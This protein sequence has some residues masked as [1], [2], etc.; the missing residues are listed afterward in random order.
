MTSE[1]ETSAVDS[2]HSETPRRKARPPFF[3][4]R[5][6]RIV[7]FSSMGIFAVFLLVFGFFYIKYAPTIN[8]RLAAGPF[9]GTVNI[10][11]APRSVAVG[12][13][14]AIDE[15]V[16]RLRRAGY[17]TSRGNTVGWYNVRQHAVEI[18]PGRDSYAGGEPGVLEFSGGKLSRIVS[19]DD[20]T[21]RKVFDLE[22]Q[23]IANLSSQRERRRLVRFSEIPEHLVQAVVSVEDKNFF[24]HAGFDAFRILK[25][26]YVDVKEGRKQQGASTL[27]MQLARGI[28]LDP[29]K[30]WKR[31]L[32]EMAISAHLERKLSKQQI[33]EY[34]A[35]QIYL[36]R[37]GT[38]S[39]HGFG[40]AA[41]VYFSKDLAQVTLPEAALLAGLIQR[42]SYF[43][44]FRH[45]ERAAE[46]RNIVLRLMRENGRLTAEQ[47]EAAAATPV[48]VQA[49][50]EEFTEAQYFVDVMNEEAQAKLAENQEER[51]R[52]IYTTLDPDLQD[53]AQNAVSKGME[54]VDRQLGCGAFKGKGKSRCGDTPPQ[55]ALV[56]IDPRTGEIRALVG[57]RN[58]NASQLNHALA[59][60]QPG[61]VFK[62]FVYA[63]ALE[64]AV[65][66][67][68]SILTPATVMND[69]PTTFY[70]E[71]QVY[72]PGNFHQNYMGPVTIRTA[73]AHS[74]NIATVELAQKVGYDRVVRLARRV[75][76]NEA[77]KPTPAVALGAY[78]TTPLEIAGAYTTFANDGVRVTPTT[79]SLVRGPDGAILYQHQPDRRNTLDP[80]VNYL[81]VSMMQ[82]V[83]RYG[84]GAGVR[85]RGFS[86][87]AAGKTGTSHDGWFAGFTSNLLCVVWV[88]F[89]D[90]RELK[91]EGS[92]SAVPIWAEFMKQATKFPR[93][94]DVRTFRPPSGIVSVEICPE[95]GELAGP[96]CPSDR[97]DMFISG[98]QPA[99]ECRL[100]A[101]SIVNY[102][103]RVVE[104]P[105]P[106]SS[107]TA[108]GQRTAAPSESMQG[109]RK[110]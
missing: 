77:I 82:D 90:N 95:S 18:F 26:A 102:A 43:N 49:E 71:R 85:S 84:T 21:E 87:P 89:D 39:V 54:L 57:G 83:L 94:S 64:T 61:S 46:R 8:R 59:M 19:L 51:A 74:L 29:G 108:E 6:G 30:N 7:L 42:P 69:E 16:A 80:R 75:G 58:Y 47:Y 66:G 35:N 60:R 45:P 96:Y 15:V 1:Q 36:G 55:V 28:W 10:F 79:I 91:L 33:F 97:G 12:D 99:I 9:S 31:K 68:S 34:Y 72:Q 107:P 78:E 2:P 40:E 22:P 104:T 62:P 52:H 41:R 73:L 103:D 88:G 98:T 109:Q 70:F 110:F 4:R 50:K 100:H 53:A 32:E 48:E 24:R 105:P 11:S 3:E 38:F 25:A 67:G 20:H 44:P 106:T 17:S 101:M 56:A 23:L 37:R 13:T 63:A 27:T 5:E 92:K 81:M 14:L 86:L 65:T 76:L 93:Y